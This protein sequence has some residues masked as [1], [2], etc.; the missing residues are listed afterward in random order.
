MAD[1]APDALDALLDETTFGTVERQ[2]SI[3]DMMVSLRRAETTLKAKDVQLFV[4]AVAANKTST[5]L[6]EAR[7]QCIFNLLVAR[8]EAL[9]SKIPAEELKEW[10]QMQTH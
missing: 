5:K 3:R 2:Q 9:A 8:F 4:D 7:V 6:H 10:K 1:A